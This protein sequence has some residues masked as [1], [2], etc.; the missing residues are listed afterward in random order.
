MRLRI[1]G[2]LA[3]PFMILA[4]TASGFEWLTHNGMARNARDIFL[5]Q[6]SSHQPPH[7]LEGSP[8]DIAEFLRFLQVVDAN[9]HFELDSRAGDP[10]VGA[11]VDEDHSEGDLKA[12]VW[13]WY[14]DRPCFSLPEYFPESARDS[15][16]VIA[17]T[18]DH[19]SPK[20]NLNLGQTDAITHARR[21]FDIAV[22]LYKAAKC[23]SVGMDDTYYTWAARALGH[24]I[25]LAEDMGSPQHA[26]PEN[27]APFPIGTGPSYV[28]YWS[29]DV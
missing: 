7:S 23:D 28:E 5:G 13:C 14:E 15:A 17:C 4:S 9:G 18:R 22:K 29:V 1:L 8:K 21:Y 6:L 10:F 16:N 25:H 20:L 12:F 19:F 3:A 26:R 27:H 11:N 2:L 24:A